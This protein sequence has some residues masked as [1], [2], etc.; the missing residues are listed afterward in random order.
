MD[1]SGDGLAS[2]DAAASMSIVLIRVS[3]MKIPRGRLYRRARSATNAEIAGCVEKAWPGSRVQRVRQFERGKVNSNYLVRLENGPADTVVVRVAERIGRLAREAAIIQ[4]VR[5]VTNLLVPEV[6]LLDSTRT[7]LD[8]EYLIIEYVR[9]RTLTEYLTHSRCPRQ[10]Q[11][12]IRRIGEHARM[13]HECRCEIHESNQ[14]NWSAGSTCGD[15][16]LVNVFGRPLCE[17]ID[18]R[19]DKIR[20]QDPSAYVWL[21]GDLTGD[22]I[23]IGEGYVEKSSITFIDL[24]SVRKWLRWW[25]CVCM[26][27]Y[28]L[29]DRPYMR[30]PFYAGLGMSSPPEAEQLTE[31]YLAF[32]CRLA[33]FSWLTRN[34]SL[35][36]E[37]RK[38]V[39]SLL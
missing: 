38:R 8:R 32:C 10:E 37:L 12:L 7:V 20:N 33:R 17:T 25:D 14:S 11:V 34:R 21:H 15:S 16:V 27:V 36:Q 6:L 30:A 39:E 1:M 19:L 4:R 24:E 35:S 3:C 5:D 31:A 9:G 23:I 29:E 26:E 18:V 22:N 13:F 2:L 28:V